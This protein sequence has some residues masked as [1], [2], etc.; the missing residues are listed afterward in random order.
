MESFLIFFPFEQIL[1]NR[2]V[3]QRCCFSEHTSIRHHA[4]FSWFCVIGNMLL[5]T[6]LMIFFDFLNTVFLKTMPNF[7]LALLIISLGRSDECEKMLVYMC[8][9]MANRQPSQKFLKGF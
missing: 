6:P 4:F 3:G 2:E 5:K 9:F 7:F 8:G 1:D